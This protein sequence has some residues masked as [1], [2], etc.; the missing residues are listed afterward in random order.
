MILLMSTSLDG[1]VAGPGGVLDWL[2]EPGEPADSCGAARHTANLELLHE[3]GAIVLGRA[4]HDEMAPAWSSSESPMAR[5][6]NALPKVVFTSSPLELE[7]I[8]AER[9]SRPLGEE[10]AA[11][12]AEVDGRLVCFGG[13]KLAHS[14]VREGLVQEYRLT[15]HPVALG[16]G[17]PLWQ[18]LPEPR[19]LRVLG[20]TAWADGAVTYRLTG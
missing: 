5:Q 20:T 4:A 7:W 8:N 14:L 19:R 18:G 12:E 13:G 2:T 6:M 3:V 17:L 9:A 10:V 15:V 11:L 1:Y 16:D